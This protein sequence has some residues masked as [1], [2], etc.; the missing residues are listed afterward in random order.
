EAPP[1]TLYLSGGN[2]YN[3]A[4]T[5]SW[6]SATEQQNIGQITVYPGMSP[7][8]MLSDGLIYVATVPTAPLF[9]PEVC[10]Q[11]MAC[12]DSSGLIRLQLK[13]QTDGLTSLPIL[14]VAQAPVPVLLD[15]PLYGVQPVTA[16]IGA[17]LAS[18]GGI[19][20]LTAATIE[21]D[22]ETLTL[23]LRWHITAPP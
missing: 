14:N 3:P 23:A 22:D 4:L 9:T 12:D 1:L 13:W 15:G 2:P 17:P 21:H 6:L 10:Q 11:D 8:D 16:G 20:T 7:T 18:F 19:V 5:V